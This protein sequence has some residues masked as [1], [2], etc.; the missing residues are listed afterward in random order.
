VGHRGN[1]LQVGGG[2]I[3]PLALDEIKKGPSFEKK[4]TEGEKGR[5]EGGRPGVG[6]KR[7]RQAWG[8]R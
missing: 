5:R 1:S 2:T 3:V 6:E 7:A 8:A 4:L